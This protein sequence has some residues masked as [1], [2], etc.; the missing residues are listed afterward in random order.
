MKLILIYIFIFFLLTFTDSFSKIED[1]KVW[2]NM[3][4]SCVPSATKG[5]NNLTLFDAKVYCEY[6]ANNGT[7][8]FTI[9]E[10]IL[11]ESQL[12]TLNEDDRVSLMLLNKK[13]K[14]MV[15]NC[16]SKI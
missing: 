13:T 3:Y 16:L 6:I 1:P 11:L 7:N 15:A 9:E 8:K 10:L 12:E 5:L 4:N 2:N 14:S